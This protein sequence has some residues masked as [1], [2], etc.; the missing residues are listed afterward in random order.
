MHY[1]LLDTVIGPLTLVASDARLHRVAF[2]AL[3][4]RPDWTL[5]PVEPA[6]TQ[7]R[8]YF[9]GTRTTFDLQ[10]APAGTPFQRQVWAEL[11]RIPHG[12]TR[13]YGELAERIGRPGA[14]RAVGAANR[15]NPIAIVQPCHRVIG[16]NG[17]LTGFAGG[18]DAKRTLLALE[19]APVVTKVKPC[20]LPLAR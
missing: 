19:G 20:E 11:R 15:N 18:L 1:Q 6:A 12:Q 14:A 3:T 5:A 2:G 10:L 4:P 9:A 7:L 8:E 17:Q 16:A 13:S